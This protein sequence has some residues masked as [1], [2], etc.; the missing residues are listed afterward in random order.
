MISNIKQKRKKEFR[1]I[2]EVVETRR[3]SQ[4]CYQ[5]DLCETVWHGSEKAKLL[6][7]FEYLGFT[8]SGLSSFFLA[9]KCEVKLILQAF[10]SQVS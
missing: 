1:I 5:T 6:C 7:V 4:Q 9:F 3:A 8:K 10:K 2:L